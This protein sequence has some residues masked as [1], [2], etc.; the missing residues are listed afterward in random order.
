MPPEANFKSW[1]TGRVPKH[2]HCQTIETTTGRGIPDLNICNDAGEMWL[3]I[4]AAHKRP[5]LRPEQYAWISRR[6]ACGGKAFVLHRCDEDIFTWAIYGPP[7]WETRV[8]GSYVE[9]ISPPMAQGQGIQPL[10]ITLLD[11]QHGR[12]PTTTPWD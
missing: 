12:N 3:E 6:H 2:W 4:K 9:I 7:N 1:L 5:H 8:S 11:L 10:I